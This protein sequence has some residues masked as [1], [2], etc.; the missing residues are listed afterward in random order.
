MAT[1]VREQ[2][3]F[4]PAEAGVELHDAG[5]APVAGAC[6]AWPPVRTSADRAS[7]PWCSRRP[8]RMSAAEGGKLVWCNARAARRRLLRTGRFQD[9]RRRM[10]RAPHR[11]PRRDV[12][13]RR[14]GRG[15]M[16]DNTEVR[17]PEVVDL[18]QQMI[19][20]ACVNDGTRRVRSRGRQRRAA[21][22][23]SR[24]DG[25][26]PRDLRTAPGSR[27]ARGADRGKRPG[28]AG[29]LLSRPHRR[30]AG[31]PRH[32]EPRPVLRRPRRRRGLGQGRGR[33]AEHHRLDGRSRSSG[34]PGAGS[35][36]KGASSW[37]RSPTRRPS[38]P[39]VPAG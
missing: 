21:A 39:T 17:D 30:R 29:A 32:L 7:G 13:Q 9:P 18:L 5:P 23:E 15:D 28:G 14:D 34:S 10:G 24:R 33:H 31:E 4:D 1:M 11:A 20:N 35:V 36:R 16:T 6:A 25:L 37:P 8:W 38:A 26:R 19:R 3:P 22:H 27:L 12:A 2:A